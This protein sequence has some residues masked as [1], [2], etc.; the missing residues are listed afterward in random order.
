MEEWSIKDFLCNNCSKYK[1]SC[2]G[3]EEFCKKLLLIFF[4]KIF[5]GDLDDFQKKLEENPNKPVTPQSI[6]KLFEKVKEKSYED[7]KEQAKLDEQ[8]R[9]FFI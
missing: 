7:L 6:D 3:N 8:F 4:T 2:K 1:K 9:N 5:N